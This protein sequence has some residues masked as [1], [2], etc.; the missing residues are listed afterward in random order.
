VPRGL[1]QRDVA[2][3]DAIGRGLKIKDVAAATGVPI[4]TA[5]TRLR[6]VRRYLL[7]RMRREK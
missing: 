6:K 2:L 1:T 7:A 5:G 3:L 4:G